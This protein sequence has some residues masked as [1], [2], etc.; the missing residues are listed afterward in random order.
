LRRELDETVE[1]LRHL[2]TALGECANYFQDSDLSHIAEGS[3]MVFDAAMKIFAKQVYFQERS[4]EEPPEEDYPEEEEFEKL[5][6]VDFH[7]LE[8][9]RNA[10]N[11][12][13]WY[14]VGGRLMNQ[15]I[16]LE[17]FTRMLDQMLTFIHGQLPQVEAKLMEAREKIEPVG[18]DEEYREEF[19]SLSQQFSE[20][21][22][23][24]AGAL[25]GA[26]TAV[27]AGEPSELQSAM[28]YLMDMTA[29]MQNLDTSL[30][31][32]IADLKEKHS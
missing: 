22:R 11:L 30:N 1:G 16:P 21:I 14:Q 10:A 9:S 5:N 17:A 24:F 4:L 3:S 18:V 13:D 25:E 28:E 23:D 27:A 2:R 20:C 15:E 12:V 7:P 29:K 19:E 31:K 32:L 26:K 6:F 8:S